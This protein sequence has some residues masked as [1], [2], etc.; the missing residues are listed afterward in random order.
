[1]EE[2]ALFPRDSWSSEKELLA[3]LSKGHKCYAA[4]YHNKIV[5]FTWCNFVNCHSIL[6]NFPLK[7]NEAYLYDAYTTESFRGKGIAP[8][9]R[10]KFYEALHTMERDVFYSISLLFNKSAVRFKSKLDARLLL[11][12][13]HFKRP[14]KNYLSLKIKDFAC[15]DH[16]RSRTKLINLS[17]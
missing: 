6:Y 15:P 17:F 1:M 14:K 11:L 13:I 5:A 2:I 12:A 7:E 4:K 9:L 3:R 10:C 8:Y 16:L